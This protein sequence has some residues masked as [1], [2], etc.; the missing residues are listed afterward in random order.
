MRQKQL[1]IF[2]LD[3][4]LMDTSQGVRKGLAHTIAAMGLPPLPPEE[5]P[6]FIGPPIHQPLQ[7]Y[8]GL[9]DEQAKQALDIFREAYRLQYLLEAEIYP[10]I[11]PLLD[12]LRSQGRHTA[13]ATNK[14][15]D[16]TKQLLAHFDLTRRFD[17]IMGSDFAGKRTKADS[18]EACVAHFPAVAKT[19]AV[20]V[21]DTVHDAVGAVKS[22]VDF[23]A[24]GYGFAPWDAE[25]VKA[26]EAKAFCPGVTDLAQCLGA[27]DKG[28]EN[29]A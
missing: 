4:T 20:M 13:V 12:R 17:F 10:G 2:D 19:E 28:A 26:N 18:I 9:T 1:I 25:K 3:G 5:M 27:G 29:D 8:Y 24:V 22:G 14:R 15:D 16:Y 11:V 21:G 6:A 23:V 7:A